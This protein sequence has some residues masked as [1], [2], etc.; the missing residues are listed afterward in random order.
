MVRAAHSLFDTEALR[1]GLA[2][3]FQ[4]LPTFDACRFF[5]SFINDT[6]QLEAAG[7]LY[8]LRVY[9][10]GWRTAAQAASEMAIIEATAARGGSVARPVP[11]SDGGFVLELE[12]PEAIRPAVLFHE[13]A[14][15]D[16]VFAGEG[17]AARARLYGRTAATLHGAMDALP[18]FADRPGWLR[19]A[20]LDHPVEVIGRVMDATSRAALERV[21][22]RLDQVLSDPPELTLAMCH[23]DL[24]TSNLHF[25]GES[26]VAIDF[27]CA[28]WGWRAN[29]ISGFAR[30]VTLARLP[31]EAATAL[32]GGFLSGYQ[33]VRA[34]PPA[35]YN[36]L[37]AFLLIQRIWIV[38]LHLE[39]RDRWGLNNFGPAYVQRFSDWLA[40]WASILDERPDWLI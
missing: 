5:R 31:G 12:A 40:A 8:Y 10:A 16:L 25:V 15:A 4:G 34:I 33:S 19:S 26:G 6:Y 36:A 11:R 14:G 39:G 18:A 3:V 27:D 17:A 37:P 21:A 23:G 29:D 22:E 24:N 1:Q 2:G 30:G 7:R 20:V 32:I 9:Q 13:A 28:A 38:S 35:D